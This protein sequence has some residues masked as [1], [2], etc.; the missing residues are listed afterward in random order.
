M[1]ASWIEI[2]RE[3][4]ARASQAKVAQR[5]DYSAS[6]ISAV[7][8][9][10][11]KGDLKRVQAAVEGALMG[12]EVRCPVLGSIPRQRCVEHQRSVAGATNPWRVQLARA[13]PACPNNLNAGKAGQES[14]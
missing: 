14:A 8:S 12:T 2:L 3:A 7:L 9:G 13:C 1:S 10:T 5:I 4:C 11:Y 6:V